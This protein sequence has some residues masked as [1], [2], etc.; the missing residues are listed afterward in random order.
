MLSFDK[1]FKEVHHIHLIGIGGISMSAIAEILLNHG[2]TVSGSDLRDSNILQKLRNHGAEVYIGHRPENITNPDLIV[3]T[4]AIKNNNPERIRAKELEIK[5]I[6]RAEM[7]GIIMKKYE[8]SIAVAGSHGKTTTTSLVSLI[9]EYT[10]FDP[11]ILIGGELDEIG[12]NIKIGSSQHFIT[13]ACEYVES[14]LKFNPFIGIILNIDADHLDYF[15]DIHHVKDA[16]KKFGMKIPKEGFLVAN[17]DDQNILDI[18]PQIHCNII[19]YGLS[20]DC[21]FRAVN[22]NYNENGF[23]SFEVLYKGNS[24][25]SFT[26]SIPGLHNIYNS[27]ASIATAYI[28]GA[29]PLDIS[30]SITIY[31]GA[32]RRF[33]ILGEIDGVK[34][35]DD[36]AHHPVE[37]MATLEA[38]TNYPHNRIWCVFQ[39]H[40]YTR[41]L[42]LFDDFSKAFDKAHH[43]I[44]TDI[45]AA[46]EQDEGKI[47]SKTLADAIIHPDVR[48]IKD[49]DE[50]AEYISQNME[51][52]DI[53]LTMGAGDIY[54]VGEKILKIEN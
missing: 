51:E 13:E 34:I 41:T 37:V 40:T 42:A 38:A 52:R 10:G 46:R 29:S 27:L 44:I 48:Y 14:F 20:N 9:L 2:Y 35:I 39:P 5:E 36:Y 30:K 25:G 24:F 22:I 19:T 45:Y 6:D 7:L 49:F 18:L 43:V 11:T 47:H 8:K 23:P 21:D 3:Y 28:L 15:K 17:A 4:A 1:T 32:H 16:F 33:D 12:G 26:L 53:V 31:K 54:Q 50:I